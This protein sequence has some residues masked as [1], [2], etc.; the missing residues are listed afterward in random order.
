MQV[1]SSAMICSFVTQMDQ[2]IVDPGLN[3]YTA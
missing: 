1:N 2:Q 3:Y